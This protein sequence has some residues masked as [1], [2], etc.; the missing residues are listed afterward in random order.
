M[1]LWDFLFTLF[2]LAPI[3]TGGVWLHR[4]DMHIEYTQPGAAAVLLCAYLWWMRK[5]GKDLTGKSLVLR[6][7]SKAWNRWR[8]SLQKSP[9]FVLGAAWVLA[10]LAWFL[11]SFRRHQ[12]FGSGMADLGI[13]TNGIWNVHA[14]GFPYSSIKD[15]LSLLADHQIFLLYPLGWIFGLWPSPVFLLLLQALVLS[16]GAVALYFLARQR[17]GHAHPLLPWLP[18]AY[19]MCGPIRAANRFDFHPEAMMLPLFLFAAWLLQEKATARKIGG[20]FFLLAALAAKESAGPLACG[21]GLA[22]LLGAGPANTRAFTRKLGASVVVAGLA[23]FYFNSQVVPTLFGKAYSYADL[24]APFGSS[25]LALALAP[26]LH[27]LVFFGRLLSVTRLR[28]FFGSL[29]SFGFLPLLAPLSLL[30][31]L[32]GF[33]ML[34]LTNGEHRISLGYHYVIEPMVGIL[35]ALPAA[36]DASFVRRHAAHLLPVLGLATLLSF[37]RSEAY[38]WRVYQPTPHQAFVRDKVL[39]QIAREKTVSASYGLVSHL[40]TRRWVH[41]IP[42]LVDEHQVTVDCVAWDRS[43]NNTPMGTKEESNL[44]IMLKLLAYEKEFSCGS[45]ALYRK[46]ATSPCL[47]QAPACEESP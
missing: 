37:G 4:S 21:L 3:L 46:K 17:V 42:T 14:L 10:A 24:Y 9:G 2:V 28:F 23:L 38:F 11:T 26:F 43:V 22:W 12:A 35:F 13:F 30:A 6:Y 18:L 1:R 39:P 19:W 16:S 33:L 34:F 44:A 41:Q 40:A 25:P 15:G 32:P 47:E 8:S 27:P 20:A 7:G 31:A 29:L 45:F 36:L 5:R